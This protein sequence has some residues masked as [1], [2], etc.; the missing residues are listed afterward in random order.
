MSSLVIPSHKGM[1]TPLY[2]QCDESSCIPLPQVTEQSE[3][4]LQDD[5]AEHDCVLHGSLLVRFE[6]PLSN[7]KICL[8]PH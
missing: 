1:S 6:D 2:S 8:Q 3:A 7:N 4:I 5:Q